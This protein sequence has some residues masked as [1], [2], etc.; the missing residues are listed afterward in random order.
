M[1]ELVQEFG[2]YAE[3]VITDA[4]D[5]EAIEVQGVREFSDPKDVGRFG[6]MCEVDN[7]TPQFFSVYAKRKQGRRGVHRRLRDHPRGTAVRAGACCRARLDCLHLRADKRQVE[8]LHASNG[9]GTVVH[10]GRHS[11]IQ[12]FQKRTFT[13]LE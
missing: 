8:H 9:A 10:A 1:Q 3:T 13:E 6:V 7:E 11:S 5:Y 4:N 12:A 2:G